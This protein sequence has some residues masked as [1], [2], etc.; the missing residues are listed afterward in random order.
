MLTAAQFM[1]TTVAHMCRT[2]LPLISVIVDNLIY[3]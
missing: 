2:V 1:V 3:C